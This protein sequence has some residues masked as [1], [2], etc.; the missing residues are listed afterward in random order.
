[1]TFDVLPENPHRAL[2]ALSIYR[3]LTARQLVDLG[4]AAS[5]TVARDHVLRHLKKGRFPLVKS[6]DFG[7]WPGYG[8]L[9]HIHY[10]TPRGAKYVADHR[11]VSVN[12]IRYPKGGVQYL[13]DFFHRLATI[14]CHIAIRNWAKDNELEV[15]F[16]HHYFD[17][18]GS[19]RR[20]PTG[21][22]SHTRLDLHNGSYI[23]PDVL[24]CLTKADYTLPLA[25]EVHKF[26][27]TKRIA[28]QLQRNALAIYQNSMAVKYGLDVSN[29]VLSVHQDAKTMKRVQSLLMQAHG[30]E[31]YIQ[32]FLFNTVEQVKDDIS[33]GWNYADGKSAYIFEV[34]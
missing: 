18:T 3:Y 27:D 34:V 23:E 29:I 9:P 11:G 13:K 32:G 26:P 6:K 24:L 20:T 31:H 15:Q 5:D 16:S 19:Q 22:K 7:L 14:D 10:L 2:E 1:M 12:E 25:L 33:M 17:K 28:E 8:R 21:Q 30:F 4:I